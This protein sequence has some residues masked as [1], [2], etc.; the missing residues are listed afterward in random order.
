MT[1]RVYY[2]TDSGAPTLTNAFGDLINVLDAC[3][4]NGYGTKDPAGWSKPFSGTNKAVYRQGGDA[5]SHHHYLRVD[6]STFGG[7]GAH[8]RGY[9][10][11]TDIDTGTGMFPSSVQVI[12]TS[13]YFW[14]TSS[15]S[16][17][18]PWRIVATEKTLY[19]WIALS[20]SPNGTAV[21][22]GVPASGG[23]I[24]SVWMFGDIMSYNKGD[25][26]RC[27]IIGGSG[28]VSSSANRFLGGDAYVSNFSLGLTHYMSRPSPDGLSLMAPPYS[29]QVSKMFNAYGGYATTP[30]L[31][32]QY[33]SLS[34]IN[35]L[36]KY[37]LSKV[38]IVERYQPAS[39]STNVDLIRGE[40]PGV[41]F[42]ST[43]LTG[44]EDGDIL[45]PVAGL[46]GKTL[47][48]SSGS[49]AGTYGYAVFEISDT[50]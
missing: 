6:Q 12:P 47:M 26:Y 25:Y 17:P 32:G 14:Y 39:S 4:V 21:S 35:T 42:L 30:T 11:M 22:T 7:T 46:E 33:N 40:L 27:M 31:S 13:N 45:P 34:P 24:P 1:V 48:Y 36:N 44:F 16:T 5:T 9:V 10:E 18:R 41:Y 38:H 20:G 29:V 23:Y 2:S 8:V 50:W 28:G 49:D 37:P 3:L 15:R 19:L 43:K